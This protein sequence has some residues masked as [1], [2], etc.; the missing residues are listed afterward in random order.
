MTKED[1]QNMENIVEQP[2]PSK[3]YETVENETNKVTGDL[4]EYAVA[5]QHL[6]QEAQQ[7]LMRKIEDEHKNDE[8]R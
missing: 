6:E 8:E 2:V 5:D 3:D 4:A 7:D 1:V